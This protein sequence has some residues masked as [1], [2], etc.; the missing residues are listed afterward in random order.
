MATHGM[1]HTRIYKIWVGMMNRC[2]HYKCSNPSAIKYYIEKGITVCKRW[3]SFPSFAE[4]AF[5]NGYADDLT[6]DRIRSR[7]NYRPG[8]CRWVTMTQNLRTRA[9]VSF[10][11][12]KARDVR[13]RKAAGESVSDLAAEY[14]V[15]PQCIYKICQGIRW[16]EGII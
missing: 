12:K 14:K 13:S 16:Q 3:R 2:G 11:M 9:G 1:S 10:T 8:N 6:I 5:A 4:W 7:D 15:K